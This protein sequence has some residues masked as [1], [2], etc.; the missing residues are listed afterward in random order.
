MMTG[1]MSGRRGSG[2]PREII[3]DG[4]RWQCGEI[5]SVE[6]IQNTWIQ[7]FWRDMSTYFRGRKHAG[8]RLH[9]GF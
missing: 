2:I 8:L 5:L 9:A 6:L 7:K 3:L 1:K 4:L